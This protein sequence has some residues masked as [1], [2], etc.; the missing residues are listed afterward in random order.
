MLKVKGVGEQASAPVPLGP[1][2]I[3]A[4]PPTCMSPFF[5]AGLAP[6]TTLSSL[7]AAPQPRPPQSGT[8]NME[9]TN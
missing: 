9:S 2:P 8:Q 5:T 7:W 3:G 1:G 4:P 6:Y